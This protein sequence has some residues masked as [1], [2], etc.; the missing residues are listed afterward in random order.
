MTLTWIVLALFAC[1]PPWTLWL[2]NRGCPLRQMNWALVLAAWLLNYNQG[3]T[4]LSFCHSHCLLILNTLWVIRSWNPD[5]YDFPYVPSPLWICFLLPIAFLVLPL[6]DF[7]STTGFHLGLYD[8]VFNSIQMVLLLVLD[9]QAHITISIG[10]FNQDILS[11]LRQESS[12]VLPL[13]I[14]SAS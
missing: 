2:R 7:S 9:L 12:L 11:A 10:F 14:A 13:I 1:P 5:L 8:P 6:T 4:M 3:P